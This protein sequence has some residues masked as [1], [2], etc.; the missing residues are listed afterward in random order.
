M[1]ERPDIASAPEGPAPA[2]PAE[3]AAAPGLYAGGRRLLAPRRHTVMLIAITLAIAAIGAQGSGKVSPDPNRSHLAQYV[4][5]I[6]LEWALF[7]YVRFGLRRGGTPLAQVIGP[8]WA[9][10]RDVWKVLLATAV[11]WVV[12]EV[13]LGLVQHGLTLA[14]YSRAAEQHR[15]MALMAP[16]GVVESVIWVLLS[17]SAGFVEEVVYRG[18]L[19]RQLGLWS[20][21]A[22]LGIAASAIVFGIAHGYQGPLSVVIITCYGALFG[23]LAHVTRTLRPGILQHALEDS[24][25]GLLGAR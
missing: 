25:G 7:A 23:I 13:I 1:S 8:R 17:C 12:K 10:L 15:T 19:Q 2:R 20:G 21:S 6:A 11:F 14:G 4:V 24:I 16:H 22:A 9:A 5:L 18:Y 3:T